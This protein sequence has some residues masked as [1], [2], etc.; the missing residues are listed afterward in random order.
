MISISYLKYVW[1]RSYP[2]PWYL[3][4]RLL[5]HTLAGL[6]RSR[7]AVESVGYKRTRR[8]PRATAVPYLRTCPP[9]LAPNEPGRLKE[10]EGSRT[11]PSGHLQL[12]RKFLRSRERL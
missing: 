1:S 6:A 2:L 11:G 8:F 9:N 12:C 10:G 7:H 3:P 5:P 4:R